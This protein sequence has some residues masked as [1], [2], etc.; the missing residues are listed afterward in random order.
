MKTTG[1]IILS[2]FIGILLVAAVQAQEKTIS[3]VIQDANTGEALPGATVFITG[4]TVGTTSDMDGNFTLKFSEGNLISVSFI[5]YLTKEIAIGDQIFLNIK[6][7]ADVE[8][9]DEVVVMGY[10]SVR[11]SNVTGAVSAIEAKELS[12]LPVTDIDRALAGKVS[13]VRVNQATGAPG[14]AVSIR[15]RGVGTIGNNDPL[16]VIDGIPTKGALN[17]ISPSDI[18][19]ITILKDASSAA[20]Y[21]SRSANGV[22]VITTK[23]G[24]SGKQIITY[25]GYYGIQQH[26]RLTPM[27]NTAEYVKIYNEA[28][29]ADDRDV[30]PSAIAA[31]FAD[32]D[33][34]E[35]IFRTAPIQS[36]QLSVSGGNATS[37]YLISGDYFNQD[38][39][40]LNSFYDRYSFKANVNTKLSKKIRLNVNTNFAQSKRNVISNSG[41]GSSSDKGSVVRYAFF[42]TPG[43]PIYKENGDYVDMPDNPKFLGDGYNPVGLAN[44]FDDKRMRY[45]FLNNA[46]LEIKLFDDLVFRSNNGLNLNINDNKKFY[47]EWGDRGI[48]A[49]GSAAHSTAINTAFTTNNIFEYSKTFFALHDVRLLLGSEYIHDKTEEHGGSRQNYPQQTENFRYLD[50]GTGEQSSY[51]SAWEWA[52]SSYF[53]NLEYIFNSKYLATFTVR[54]DGSSR[55]S[56][57]NRY[58]TF[59]SGSAA[60]RLEKE[61]FMEAFAEKANI[62]L[63]KLRTSYGKLGNQEIGDY[64]WATIISGG[65]DY[66]FGAQAQSMQKGYATSSQGNTNVKWETTKQFDLGFD[67]RMYDNKLIFNADYFEKVTS[68]MLIPFPAPA[69]GGSATYPWVNAGSVENKGF[70]FELGYQNKL[71]DFSYEI[72][73]NFS[74]VK[75]EVISLSGEDAKPVIG[76]E[77]DNNT[78]VTITEVGQAIGTF[79]VYE[80]DGIFQSATE[81]LTHAYQG[82]NIKPGDVK[83]K[84]LSGA[85]GVPDGKIDA[86]DRVH[87]GS[88]IPNFT[89]GLT[90]N[91][92]YK[93]FDF[94]AFFQGVQGNK[95]YMQINK[96][97][98]GFYRAFP[99][100]KRFY[101]EHWTP[102]NPNNEFP[103]AA[104]GGATNNNRPSTRFIEDGSYVRL[105]NVQIGYTF[106]E[107]T[108]SKLK[109]E[110]VRIYVSA[111]NMLT[112]TKFSGL[113]PEMQTSEN[114]AAEGDR[115]VGID[116]GTYPTAKTYL[117]GLRVSF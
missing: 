70:E 81:I 56:E 86:F 30:I 78:F 109:I 104:W 103:R 54:R 11:K 90:V 3:G 59:Y 31:T 111:Q 32:V 46:L 85:N 13:G 102:E 52:L 65:Y 40:I 114:S 95:V 93:N 16:Y 110:Q 12:K 25:N 23:K 39:I 97:I 87:A 115:A 77:V 4:T 82:P 79:Y 73:G 48:D 55:F 24:V 113:D 43:T 45:I 91:L 50:A 98:E 75:N 92:S 26:G 106:P 35:S 67:L 108:T 89:Y 74:K 57:K 34:M 69:I 112:Y 62:G 22:V 64:P 51:G 29:I 19:S 17:V 72:T 63:L 80:M 71:G 116:W 15:I 60:W 37:Q 101:D 41:D 117:M 10:S 2:F 84:D 100:T 38:G 28:A 83:Y 76:G 6:L 96:D 49:P 27:V 105:K 20:I 107:S 88:A 8:Q 42:R 44:H 1:K 58:G 18:E 61:P 5:G 99:V 9:L 33:H 68:D 21:G 47:E 53:A 36:H 94:S 7:A 14:D 66:P